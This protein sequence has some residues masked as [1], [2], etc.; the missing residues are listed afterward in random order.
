[1]NLNKG[2][3]NVPETSN[4]TANSKMNQLFD[5]QK[6]AHLHVLYKYNGMGNYITQL[7]SYVQ[8]GIVAGIT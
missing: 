6:H 7:L 3:I 1:M 4:E 8:D 2:V 5:D